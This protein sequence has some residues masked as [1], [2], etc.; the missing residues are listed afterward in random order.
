M[1][2]IDFL[3]Q[4]DPVELARCQAMVQKDQM[5][6]NY[7]N[8]YQSYAM[9]K[10]APKPAGHRKIAR[11]RKK[12]EQIDQARLLS[13]GLLGGGLGNYLFPVGGGWV[14]GQLAPMG[15]QKAISMWRGGE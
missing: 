2:K 7:L 3:K 4:P 9:G 5:R 10:I 12:Q 8:E 11:D 13:L 14:G 15:Y 6:Q 1:R